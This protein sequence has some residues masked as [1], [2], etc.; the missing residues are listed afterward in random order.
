M[1]LGQAAQRLGERVQAALHRI[2][3]H[4]ECTDGDGAVDRLVSHRGEQ[5]EHDQ[6]PGDFAEP[7]VHHPASHQPCPVLAQILANPPGPAKEVIA[8][9]KEAHFLRVHV[10]RQDGRKI[11]GQ[12][13]GMRV[14]SLPLEEPPR[15]P[16]LDEQAGDRRDQHDEA[17]PPVVRQEQTHHHDDRDG[18]PDDTHQQVQHL[19]GSERRIVL[20]AVQRVVVGGVLVVRQIHLHRLCLQQVVNVIRDQQA[21]RVAHHRGQCVRHALDDCDAARQGDEHEKPVDHDAL[22]FGAGSLRHLIDHELEEIQRDERQH[23][24]DNHQQRGGDRVAGGAT[25]DQDERPPHM[26]KLPAPLPKRRVARAV[27]H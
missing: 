23:A 7:D 10:A 18:R 2:E 16:H 21:L 27:R 13:F 11:G 17:Q 20:R 3:E 9:T 1:E 6:R 14:A 26:P 4:D 15:M 22:V 8:E 5:P 12:P 25:P 19:R 24:L